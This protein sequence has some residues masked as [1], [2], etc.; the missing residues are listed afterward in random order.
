VIE[1]DL[2][3]TDLI[4]TGL[5]GTGPA[6]LAAASELR[7]EIDGMSCASCA[8]RIERVAGE[9][10]GVES[11]SVSFAGRS[12]TVRYRAP[13]AGPG[14]IVAAIED[15]G[16]RATPVQTQTPDPAQGYRADERYWVPRLLV[17]WPLAVA[18]LVLVMAFAAHPW[19]RWAA[20]ACATP[21]QFWMGWPFLRT[22]AVRARARSASMDTLVAL[23][24]LTGYVASLPAIAGGGHLY[25]DSAALIVAFIALGRYLEAK[26]KGRAA[27]AIHALLAL[28]ARQAHVLRDGAEHTVPVDGLAAG[29]LVV[30]RPGEKIPADGVVAGGASVVDESMLTG[31][32]VPVDKAPGDPVTGATVNGSGVLRVRLSAVGADT[33]LA[34]IVRLVAAAQASTAP[35]QRLA[36]RVAAVFVPIVLA[37]G[38]VT[39][40]VW[41][42]DG[43]VAAGVAATVAVLVVACPCAMGLAV[44]AA[45]MV[46]AGRGARSGVLIKSGEALERFRSVDAVVLDKTG[47][48]TEGRMRVAEV[49]GDPETLAMAA[50]VEAGSEHPI[51]AAIVAAGREHGLAAEPV[52]EFHAAAGHGV[53]GRIGGPESRLAAEPVDEF[54]AAA[55]H[56]VSGRIGG[57]ES[58]LAAE[59]VDEFRAAAGHGAGGRVVVAGTAAF[60]ADSGMPAGAGVAAEAA[61]LAGGGRTVVLVGWDGEARGAVAVADRLKPEAASVVAQLRGLGLRVVMLTGDGQASAASVAAQ[62]GIA[63]VIAGVPPEGKV[64]AVRRLQ[65][66]GNRVAFA[67][68]GVNDAPA[69]AQADLGM[70]IGTGSDV[71]IEAADITLVSGSLTGI[72]T[73]IRLSR[74]THRVV[75]QNLWWAFGYNVVMI[76]LA[77]LGILPPIAAGAAMAASSV[78]V[79]GNALRLARSGQTRARSGQTRARS[80]QTRAR[81]GQTRARSGQ[82]PARPGQGA[83]VA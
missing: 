61:R 44:P 78:S 38:C 65:D 45:I 71:A 63:E 69:L 62:A 4:G 15:L 35:A 73:A 50:S 72:L 18:T 60:L 31:E 2:I 68:D 16:Y 59:P 26:A 27:G 79:V 29:D 22:A 70:A 24:T 64:A 42:L 52:D 40:A 3:D 41:A 37:A 48:L 57:P 5:A 80:G 51:G 77:A 55:G 32:P 19:A 17:G 13:V 25:L 67:G 46:A 82:A 20:L 66:G 36:D 43:R 12:A 8:A 47:T 74:R 34:G 11:A 23:G 54:H 83:R 53:S 7:L 39:F 81:S 14:A 33:A 76:P 21:V 28:G 56:G 1:P 10:P 49:A 9:Q 58:R 30:V 6:G 75:V